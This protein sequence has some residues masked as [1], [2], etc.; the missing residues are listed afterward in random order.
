MCVLWDHSSLVSPGC[1][2][3][4]LWQCPVPL[5]LS[6]RAGSAQGSVHCH[7]LQREDERSGSSS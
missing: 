6:Q 1:L 2:C 5:L 7:S 3:A 4:L